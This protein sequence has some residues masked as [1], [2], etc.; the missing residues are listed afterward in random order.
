MARV[1]EALSYRSAH[2]AAT[3]AEIADHVAAASGEPC[4]A[5]TIAGYFWD[6]DGALARARKDRYRD[7]CQVCGAELHGGD[8]IGRGP[9]HCVT[10]ARITARDAVASRLLAWAERCGRIPTSTELN[11]RQA[12]RRGEEAL[13]WYEEAATSTSTVVYHYGTYRAGIEAVF[14]DGARPGQPFGQSG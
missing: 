11:R 12:G 10:C 4:S 14:G 8:G 6:P 13:A 1:S 2:P 9:S 3:R 5:K 7:R